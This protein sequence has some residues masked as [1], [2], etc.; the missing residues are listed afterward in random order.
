MCALPRLSHPPIHTL[1][2]PRGRC[3]RTEKGSSATPWRPCA[4]NSP[5]G[6][7][8]FVCLE[9]P[10]TA[11]SRRTNLPPFLQEGF[12]A[13]EAQYKEEIERR[14]QQIVAVEAMGR[15]REQW[16]ETVFDRRVKEA[17]QPC[18]DAQAALEVQAAEL[19]ADRDAARQGEEASAAKAA[20]LADEVRVRTGEG[21]RLDKE[22]GEALSRASVEEAL[23]SEADKAL[24]KVRLWPAWKCATCVEGPSHPGTPTPDRCAVGP[25]G[26]DA[27]DCGSASLPSTPLSLP[28]FL[29]LS[30]PPISFFLSLPI[31]LSPHNSLSLPS[32]SLAPSLYF[33]SL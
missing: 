15:E 33:P 29:S 6:R 9:A 11:P 4:K 16:R 27:T 5:R 23:R 13:S 28:P 3:T 25:P 8:A 24:R 7:C 31:A 21:H 32:L 2:L 30:P 19:R 12:D 26:S 17:M 10:P 20:A 22:L 14:D 18:L 1:H